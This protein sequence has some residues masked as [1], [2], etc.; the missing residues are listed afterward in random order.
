MVLYITIRVAEGEN[1]G[2]VIFTD[3]MAKIGMSPNTG[4]TVNTGQE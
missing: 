3:I 2:E 1:G 4:E